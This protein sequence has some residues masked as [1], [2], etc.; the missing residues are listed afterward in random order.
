MSI[1]SQMNSKK[2]HIYIDESGDTGMKFEKGSSELFVVSLV[3]VE[4]KN[5]SQI[6]AFF[7]EIK[8]VLRIKQKEL[9]FSQ[10]PFNK[11]VYFYKQIRHADFFAFVFV[12]KKTLDKPFSWFILNAFTHLNFDNT[13][14]IKI[15]IDGLDKNKIT[16]NDIKI[17]RHT[18][19]GIRVKIIF[20]DSKKN[21]FLQL[22][23]MLAGLVHSIDRGKGD[24]AD[25]LKDIEV[26]VKITRFG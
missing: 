3:C 1:I 25:S 22:S 24:Y 20:T 26:K 8:G 10:I 17:I 23:D 11:K 6:E 2:L 14:A 13:K 4:N 18:F 19:K 9:K 5:I 16:G 21:I 12:Y 7:A 15:I